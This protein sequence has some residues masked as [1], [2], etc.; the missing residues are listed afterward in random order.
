MND[1]EIIKFKNDDVELSVNVSPSDDTIWLTIE[2]M[3]TLFGRDRTVI[4]KH[5]NN[6]YN[7]EELDVDSTCAKFAQVQIEGQRR[8]TRQINYYNLDV[9][10]PVGYRVKSKNAMVFRRWANSILREY[11]LKGYVINDNRTL[12]TNENYINL[13]NRVDSIDSRL[14]K[15]ENNELSYK[16][17]KLIVNGDI[18][19]AITYLENIVSKA[20][21]KILLVDPYVDSKALNILKNSVD[22]IHIK[23]ITSNKSKLSQVD[24]N[25]FKKQYNKIINYVIDN[26]F[27]D[28]YLYVDNK[29]FHLGSSINY[30]GNRISQIDEVLD[31]DIKNYLMKRVGY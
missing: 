6:L 21:N 31:E 29:I 26:G 30:L 14:Q 25:A 8:I 1:F 23:I 27:H 3:A 11:L 22:N 9:I 7:D 19:D 13:I 15:I 10:I 18:F 12:V 28:R 4:L 24:L 20:N 16:K 17:E 2:Q 5:I